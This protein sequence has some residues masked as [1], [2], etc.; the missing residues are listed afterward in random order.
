MEALRFV[1][2]TRRQTCLDPELRRN[3]RIH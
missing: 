3:G 1:A 2:E